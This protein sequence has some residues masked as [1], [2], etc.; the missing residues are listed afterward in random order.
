MSELELLKILIVDDNPNNLLSLRGLIEEF[1]NDVQVIAADSGMAAL[2]IIM[3]QSVDLIIMDVQ[4]PGMDGFETAQMIRSWKKMERIPIVFLTAAYKSTEFEQRGFAIGAADYLTKPIDTVQLVSR[5]NSYLR[6]IRQEH[7]HQRELEHKVQERTV[8]LSLANQ[9]L[10]EAKQVAEA[11]NL[12]KSRFL[13][14]MSHE[15]RT[16]LNAILGYTEMLQESMED[17]GEA[18]CLADLQKIQIAGKELLELI[19]NLLDIS[20]IEMG[21]MTVCYETVNLP[22]LLDE[23]THRVQPLMDK[24]NNA[25]HC[26][27]QEDTPKEIYADLTKVRQVLVNLLDNAAKFTEGGQVTFAVTAEIQDSQEWVRFR[28]TD[29]GIGI[30]SEQLSQLFQIF[31]QADA[32]PTRKYGGTGLGL[33]ISKQFTEMMAG[34]FTMQSEVNQGT[35][36]WVK[37]PVK[38]SPSANVFKFG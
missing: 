26:N 31:T 16:P 12:A 27:Y 37:L 18:E 13:A 22:A 6:F 9:Q 25:F 28:I 23:V 33:A 38:G 2:N 19:S 29:T 34:T 35:T 15:L 24:R 8:E 14:N 17:L 7:Q 20:K 10:Q 4:M 36:V 3:K 32:S 21:R 1:I 11:A 30:T 5:M